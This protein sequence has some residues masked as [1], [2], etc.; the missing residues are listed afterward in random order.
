M[1]EDGESSVLMQYI[2]TR[3][4]Q[5]DSNSG[6]NGGRIQYALFKLGLL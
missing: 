3:F 6:A 1:V 4:T 5:C 2:T